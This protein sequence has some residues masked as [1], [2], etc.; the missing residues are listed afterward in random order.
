MLV[1]SALSA[2]QEKGPEKGL[3]LFTVFTPTYNR[4]HLLS[5]VYES[6]CAQSCRDFEWLIVDD[7]STDDTRAWVEQCCLIAPFSVRYVWQTNSHKKAALNQG[8]KLALGELFVVLDSDDTLLPE[9][10]AS[11]QRLWHDIPVTQ[12]GSF[13]AVT[14]L[15]VRPD[16]S[17]VGDSY[18]ADVIDSTPMDMI[19]RYQVKGEKF[20]FQR[21][22]VMRQYPFP[23]DVSGY[24]PES[25]IWWRIAK[26]GYKTRFV[27]VVLRTYYDSPDSITRGDDQAVSSDASIQG[28]RA[29]AHDT[30]THHLN[31]FWIRP[32]A[33]V[34]AAARH[35]R[36]SLRAKWL[37]SDLTKTTEPIGQMTVCADPYQ[38]R[39][40]L[41]V[42]LI[43]V[44]YPLGFALY[45][46]D[47]LRRAK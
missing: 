26:A 11:M 46:R 14:G 3:F 18:P 32:M 35:T 17:I 40:P 41:A 21:T 47:R 38:V 20:G 27:N 10:L 6:L 39:R 19:L 15:C 8:V 25:I 7:G 13:S 44:T 1:D 29:L 2:I 31:W 43:V 24:L 33:F 23:E 37:G 22:E 12:R 5:R 16:G 30:L 36:F 45:L 34:L 42:V 28:L 9:A 4:A